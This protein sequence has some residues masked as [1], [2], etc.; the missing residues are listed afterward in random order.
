MS[1]MAS[2]PNSHTTSKPSDIEW[3]GG[4]LEHWEVV[5]SR[6]TRL[7]SLTLPMNQVARTYTLP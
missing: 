7:M 5:G 3:L 4:V 6:A 1:S 2:N